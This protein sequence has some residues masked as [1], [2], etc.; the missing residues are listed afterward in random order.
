MTEVKGEVSNEVE[1]SNETENYKKI[2]PEGEVNKGEC[3]SFWK[4]AMKENIVPSEKNEN[5]AECDSCRSS[6]WKKTPEPAKKVWTWK[7]S[8]P[9]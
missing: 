1:G 5:K 4:S 7:H 6:W 3:N 8:V 2:K 9:K